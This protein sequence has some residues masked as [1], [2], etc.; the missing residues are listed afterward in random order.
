MLA[1]RRFVLDG[2]MKQSVSF[3]SAFIMADSDDDDRRRAKRDGKRKATDATSS[4]VFSSPY[5]EQM[6]F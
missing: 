5:E 6:T 3:N 2:G 4:E 1:C